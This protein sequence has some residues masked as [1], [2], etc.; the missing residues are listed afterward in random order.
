MKQI[1]VA[2]WNINSFE[3]FIIECTLL[4]VTLA[5]YLTFHCI[6]FVIYR[7]FRYLCH[8]LFLGIT[9]P[10]ISKNVPINMGPKMNMFR[11][12]QCCVEI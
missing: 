1:H 10:K 9:N 3:D 7:V 4:I 5:L 11:L 8:K 6:V 12:I 2:S